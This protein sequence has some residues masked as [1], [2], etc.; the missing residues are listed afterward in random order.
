MSHLTD[1]EI[2]HNTDEIN[3]LSFCNHPNIVKY[4]ASMFFG[5][6]L[7]IVM[8]FMEGGTLAEAV[9]RHSFNEMQIAFV[10]KSILDALVWMHDR[11]LVHRDLKSSN[12]MMTTIGSVKLIDFGLCVDIS[13]GA[14][15]NMVGSP[16]WMPPEMIQRKAHDF[17]ADVWS[18][19]ISLLE[20]A[21]KTPPH[22]KSSIKCMF[23]YATDGCPEPLN[24]P[25][26]WS[27]KFKEFLK[28]CLQKDPTQR[29]TVRQLLEHPFLQKRISAKQMAM[30]IRHI[31]VQTA[32]E[33]VL[34]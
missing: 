18:F 1:K 11:N 16:F 32:L 24:E 5:N 13:D 27:D 9:K 14:K 7:W 17:A 3:F 30:L 23:T 2:K 21:N 28:C 19:A 34:F 12:I 15:R 25:N 29:Q 26:R 33:Q 22:R 4:Y 31:F 20:L 10:A 6:E 8:E